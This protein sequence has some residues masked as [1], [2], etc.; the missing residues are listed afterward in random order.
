MTEQ[1]GF[2]EE[3]VLIYEF[4]TYLV[5]TRFISRNGASRAIAVAIDSFNETKVA[6]AVKRHY[7]EAKR[8]IFTQEVA[9]QLAECRAC[10]EE[11]PASYLHF[12]LVGDEYQLVALDAN[13]VTQAVVGPRTKTIRT[14]RQPDHLGEALK[15]LFGP[16][17]FIEDEK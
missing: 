3:Y 11:L 7:P 8:F 10:P 16:V 1:L 12:H 15:Y 4:D 13:D 14:L 5:S 6:M 17:E 2:T 9:D